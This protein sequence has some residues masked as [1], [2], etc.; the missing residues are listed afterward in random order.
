MSI[1]GSVRVRVYTFTKKKLQYRCFPA[2]LAK[3]LRKNVFIE[4]PR[5]LL[6]LLQIFRTDESKSY[7]LIH[8]T[9]GE[10]AV[11]LFNFSLPL[12]PVSQTLRH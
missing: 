3:F 2:N 10:G 8:R 1:T 4:E 7:L 12:P 6:L 9:A 5:W 11:Y